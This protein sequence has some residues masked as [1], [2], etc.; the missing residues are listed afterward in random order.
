MI[1]RG[2]QLI[3][4]R[5]PNDPK[6]DTH[7]FLFRVRSQFLHIY[8]RNDFQD[9][10]K[11]VPAFI[12]NDVLEAIFRGEVNVILIC[13]GINSSLEIHTVNVVEVPPV[14]R[15]FSRLDPRS[16]LQLRGLRQKPH[17]LVG[18]QVAVFLSDA[19]EAPGKSARAR[20]CGNVVG[21]FN[22]AEVSVFLQFFFQRVTRKCSDKCRAVGTVQPHPGI[23]FHIG[24]G[25]REFGAFAGIH[26]RGHGCD[27]S[28]ID[29]LQTLGNIFSFVMGKHAV[30]L[31]IKDGGVSREIEFHFFA[32]DFNLL[33]RKGRF[34]PVGCALVVGAKD[35]GVAAFHFDPYFI[36]VLSNFCELLMDGGLQGLVVAM[37]FCGADLRVHAQSLMVNVERKS[38]ILEQGA[39]L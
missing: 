31:R 34:K 33:L 2:N 25:D 6:D 35:D 22:D 4:E 10:S 38:A 8:F 9:I 24:F 28:R 16:V 37:F 39:A 5:F 17:E 19:H 21:G 12:Q 3:V 26:N 13:L 1:E 18:Q 20:S 15:D 11:L 29:F 14:P 36:V 32:V 7:V 23:I 27:E 30:F